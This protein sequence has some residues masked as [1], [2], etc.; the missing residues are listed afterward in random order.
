MF[1]VVLLL[2]Q[3]KEGH[4]SVLDEHRVRFLHIFAI[5]DVNVELLGLR[6]TRKDL[7][8]LLIPSGISS[9]NFWST[10]PSDETV[11]HVLR[12]RFILLKFLQEN[13]LVKFENLSHIGEEN[14]LFAH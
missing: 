2:H 5:M 8:T 13:V 12:H 7:V 11:A 3:L 6:A 1:D 10:H 14:V 9:I 4:A